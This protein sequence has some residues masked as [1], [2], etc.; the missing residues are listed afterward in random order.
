M[1]SVPLSN[2]GAAALLPLAE[3]ALAATAA[4]AG[5]GAGVGEGA[6]AGAFCCAAAFPLSKVTA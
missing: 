1:V 2:F 4:G 6:G 3:D 5:A